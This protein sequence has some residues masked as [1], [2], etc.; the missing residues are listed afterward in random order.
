M[1]K[2]KVKAGAI[3]VCAAA[4]FGIVAFCML[5]A[6]QLT[7]ENVDALNGI[8]IAFGYTEGG[9]YIS[10]KVLN[11]S[12]GNFMTYAFLI[13]GLLFAAL[14]LTGKLLGKISAL[15]S[16]AAFICAGA[17]F[18]CALQF[19]SVNV[20]ELTGDAAQLMIDTFK[21]GYSLGAGAIAGGVLSILGG[22][23]MLCKLFIKN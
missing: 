3:A 1:A 4:V 6:P 16:A 23:A 11:F 17:F 20:G 18:F 2:K 14:S 19:V 7:G 15:I 10:V 8:K 5:F 21:S 13:I 22:C 9:S 12:F